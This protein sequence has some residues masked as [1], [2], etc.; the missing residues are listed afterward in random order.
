MVEVNQELAAKLALSCN[1]LGQE[2]QSDLTLCH[3]SARLPGEEYLHMKPSALS[4]DEVCA[5]DIIVIDLEGNKLAGQRR[6][7]TE[8]PIHTEICKLRPEIN[9]VI[10]THPPY[11]T[12]LGAVGG[13]LHAV[14]HEGALFVDLPLFTETSELIRT[15]AQGQAV[16]R[17]LGQARAVLLQNHGG[18]VVGQTIE[19]ATVYA[20]LLEKAAG[21]EHLARQFGQPVWSSEQ[22]SQRKVEQIYHPG[23]MQ[24]YWDYFARRAQSS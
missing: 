18:V 2:G 23:A 4:L 1:I 13:G 6:R 12:A 15:A 8:Y 10:H 3:V 7:H 21:R 24:R 22:E 20:I 19:E 14:S 9:S 5:E 11:T 17:C 16:A